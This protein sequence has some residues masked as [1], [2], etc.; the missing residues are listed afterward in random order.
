MVLPV[1]DRGFAA[2]DVPPLDALSR[3][4]EPGKVNFVMI[5]V[6][7]HVAGCREPPATFLDAGLELEPF[8]RVGRGGSELVD[9]RAAELDERRSARRLYPGIREIQIGDR[10]VVLAVEIEDLV[11]AVGQTVAAQRP[12]R[13]KRRG[14]AGDS[15]VEIDRA[16]EA[17]LTGDS[18]DL[19]DIRRVDVVL[20]VGGRGA[21]ECQPPRRIELHVGAIDVQPG[22]VG[23]LAGIPPFD[24]CRRDLH[25]ADERRPQ[26]DPPIDLDRCRRDRRLQIVEMQRR[27]DGA[28]DVADERV[29][30][31]EDGGVELVERALRRD[32]QRCRRR[33]RS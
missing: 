33:C 17:L 2:F 15:A 21:S 31:R 9:L 1:L 12:A 10:D 6:K 29:T 28:I 8:L 5:G 11:V 19:G 18:A 30:V 22:D 20:E 32:G 16:F 3:Q 14:V 7:D 26:R 25:A 27:V 24:I 23:D 13:L 4:G